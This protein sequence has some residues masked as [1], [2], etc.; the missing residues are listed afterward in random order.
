MDDNHNYSNL[1]N[2]KQGVVRSSCKGCSLPVDFV[3]SYLCGTGRELE[4]QSMGEVK[5][6]CLIP[7]TLRQ[8]F[9]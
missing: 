3:G 6:N 1:P 2:Y 9:H 4:G 8:T 5:S 7:L